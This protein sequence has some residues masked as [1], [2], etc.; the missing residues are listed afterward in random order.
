[1]SHPYASPQEIPNPYQGLSH[2]EQQHQ[3]VLMMQQQQQLAPGQVVVVQTTTTTYHQQP[4]YPMPYGAMYSDQFSMMMNQSYEPPQSLDQLPFF[5]SVSSSVQDKKTEVEPVLFNFDNLVVD[6]LIPNYLPAYCLQQKQNTE[7]N[8]VV[9]NTNVNNTNNSTLVDNLTTTKVQNN[10]VNFNPVNTISKQSITNVIENNNVTI[11]NTKNV[12]NQVTNI[13]NVTSKVVPSTPTVSVNTLTN[14]DTQKKAVTCEVV[15]KVVNNSTTNTLVETKDVKKDDK[16]VNNTSTVVKTIKDVK[17][18]STTNTLVENKDINHHVTINNSKT[19]ETNIIATNNASPVTTTTHTSTSVPKPTKEVVSQKT[20]SELNT[21]S[22]SVV[23]TSTNI[24]TSEVTISNISTNVVNNINNIT[25]VVNNV[26]KNSV[27]NNEIDKTTSINNINSQTKDIQNQ[28]GTTQETVMNSVKVEN[29]K[30]I[31]VTNNISNTTNNTTVNNITNTCVDTKNV[32]AQQ[33]DCSKPQRKWVIET[34]IENF[35]NNF[36]HLSGVSPLYLSTL[37]TLEKYQSTLRKTLEMATGENVEKFTALA[38]QCDNE[39]EKSMG[40]LERT[41]VM[42]E[43]EKVAFMNWTENKNLPNFLNMTV[44]QLI[45]QCKK[46]PSHPKFDESV[47]TLIDY[48]QRYGKLV[49]YLV[50]LRYYYTSIHK[51]YDPP[52][53][54]LARTEKCSVSKMYNDNDFDHTWDALKSSVSYWLRPCQFSDKPVLF[55]NDTLDVNRIRK[56]LINNAYF[57]SAV[58]AAGQKSPE[59]IKRRFVEDDFVGGR[60]TVKLFNSQNREKFVTVDDCFPIEYLGK[61]HCNKLFS[62][63]RV[64]ATHLGESLRKDAWRL[65]LVLSWRKS[66]LSASSSFW[67]QGVHQA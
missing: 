2:H 55:E 15:K 53:I 51:K 28:S 45:E 6:A 49:Q 32:T 11:N 65:S 35:K 27:V 42:L 4:V 36:S 19:V 29:T 25:N 59:A 14:T 39:F 41:I 57:I 30:N 61:T 46:L 1:M 50:L 18:I 20:T 3:Q 7:N 43:R 33:N 37:S 31:F 9:N 40:W 64:L 38:I 48:F 66:R 24:S 54:V 26:V 22:S 16:V 47:K 12:T 17:N 13:T 52:K 34:T 62:S 58:I 63:K 44:E 10:S 56:G 23:N 8:T 60:H 21:T 67:L 5:S